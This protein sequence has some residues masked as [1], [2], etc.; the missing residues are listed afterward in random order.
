[1]VLFPSP[2]CSALATSGSIKM[3]GLLQSCISLSSGLQTF[4]EKRRPPKKLKVDC[5][6][7]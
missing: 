4:E 2:I 3:V 6:L 7:D 1:M 5:G